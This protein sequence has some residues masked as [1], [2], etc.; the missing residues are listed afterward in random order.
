MDITEKYLSGF[1]TKNV[2]QEDKDGNITAS[3]SVVASERIITDNGTYFQI[4][5]DFTER[6]D[7]VVVGS[8]FGDFKITPQTKVVGNVAA[9]ATFV[10]VESTIGFPDSGELSIRFDNNDVGIVTYKSKNITQFLDLDGLNEGVLDKGEIFDTSR[11]YGVLDDGTEFDFRIK[12]SLGDYK[13]K[14]TDLGTPYFKKGDIIKN[15]SLGY[16]KN[17]IVTDSLISNETSRFEIETAKDSKPES[18]RTKSKYHFFV[19][20]SNY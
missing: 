18:T 5:L 7:S 1:I 10:D 3:G 6:K 20:N 17:N 15:Q 14:A 11:T 16:S 4:D 2:Y 19:S 12:G 13:I 9:A 8:I